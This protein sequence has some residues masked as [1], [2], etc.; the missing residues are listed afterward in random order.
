MAL[1]GDHRERV[2]K[3][4]IGSDD[5]VLRLWAARDAALVLSDGTL[6][7]ELPQLLHDPFMAVRREAL[8]CV[9]NRWP[10]EAHAALAETLLDTSQSLREFSRFHLKKLGHTDFAVHYRKAL[11][12]GASTLAAI[13][14][15]GETG[16][17]SDLPAIEPYLKHQRPRIRSAAVR[18]V[19]Q[20]AP[21]G[22]VRQLILALQDA[23][24]RVTNEAGKA[25]SRVLPLVEMGT[26]ADILNSNQPC[27][28]RLEVLD[29]VDAKGTWEAMPHLLAAAASEDEQLAFMAKAKVR[30]KFN[31]VFTKP[32]PSQQCEIQA[33]FNF[34]TG[35]LGARDPD[36][37]KEAELWLKTRM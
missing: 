5:P 9:M 4:S 19:G 6:R 27:H 7:C 2:I 21:E 34:Y 8:R 15:L 32:S 3:H 37:I 33:A 28:V 11:E 13:G 12:T 17:A 16:D 10:A 1:S 25:L 22:I 26:L 14:G 31:R 23:S 35:V 29:L 24:K 18:A 36:F 20:L 30:S